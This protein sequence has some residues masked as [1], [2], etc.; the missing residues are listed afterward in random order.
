M[1]R[2]MDV[3]V[4]FRHCIVTIVNDHSLARELITKVGCKQL[5]SPCLFGFHYYALELCCMRDSMQQILIRVPAC[6]GLFHP[7]RGPKQWNFAAQHVGPLAHE[8][9][10]HENMQS[11]RSARPPTS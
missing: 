6:G 2:Q 1:T 4:R 10:N 9:Q 5:W 8:R 3:L 7:S 11:V